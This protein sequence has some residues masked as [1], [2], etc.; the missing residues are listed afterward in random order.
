MAYSDSK[1]KHREAFWLKESDDGIVMK[2]AELQTGS[3]L[4]AME[5]ILPTVKSTITFHYES[6]NQPL[7][8]LVLKREAD[9]TKYSATT[10]VTLTNSMNS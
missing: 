7:P 5:P 4:H 1:W 3:P 9:S 8:F 6:S 10:L 2:Q